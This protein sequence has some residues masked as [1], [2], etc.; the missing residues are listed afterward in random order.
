MAFASTNNFWYTLCII[1]KVI[2]NDYETELFCMKF[3]ELMWKKYDLSIKHP[4]EEETN[5][6]FTNFATNLANDVKKL[7]KGSFGTVILGLWKSM[8]I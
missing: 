8:F 3:K 2:R 5:A 6:M 1:H 4:V 7:G